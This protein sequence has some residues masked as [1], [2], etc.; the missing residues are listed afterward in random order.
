MICGVPIGV[1][2]AFKV[3]TADFVVRPVEAGLNS[4]RQSDE[5]AGVNVGRS[6]LLQRVCSPPTDGRRALG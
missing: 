1:L 5:V 4:G 3:H 2:D 6:E